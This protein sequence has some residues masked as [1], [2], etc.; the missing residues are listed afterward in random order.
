LKEDVPSVEAFSDAIKSASTPKTLS[1]AESLGRMFSVSLPESLDAELIQTTMLQWKKF[2]M[3]PAGMAAAVL[4]LF[5]VA[6]HDRDT[7][8]PVALDENAV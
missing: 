3:L 5:L 8:E 2:W 4:V 7:S 6:F 1:F